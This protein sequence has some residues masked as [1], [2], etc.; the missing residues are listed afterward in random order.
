MTN[1]LLVQSHH[2]LDLVMNL[3]DE[4]WH[5]LTNHRGRRCNHGR[6]WIRMWRLETFPYFLA[7]DTY[8]LLLSRWLLIPL[9][10]IYEIG[11]AIG[12]FSYDLSTDCYKIA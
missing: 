8:H 2:H 10:K 3:Y 7:S 4:N 12:E 5:Y 11:I 9:I 6:M 1:Y